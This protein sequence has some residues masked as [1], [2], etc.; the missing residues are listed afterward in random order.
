MR[1]TAPRPPRRLFLA[2]VLAALTAGGVTALVALGAVDQPRTETFQF[3]RGTSFAGGEEARL[4]GFLAEA[5]TD[6]RVTVTVI[7]HSGT[8]GD[9]DANVA[10]SQ[11]RADLV[12]DMAAGMGIDD[13][14]LSAS[15][16]GGASPLP[17]PDGV[18]DRAHEAALSRV[19]V[20]LQVRR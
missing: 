18:S 8:Q 20:S 1:E 4:R 5:A 2:S 10:L 17:K 9:S 12:A 6:A 3:A 15:G 16:I 7:G 13:T 14:R 19:D 11:S